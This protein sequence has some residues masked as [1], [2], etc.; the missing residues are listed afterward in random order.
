MNASHRTGRAGPGTGL[1]R[2]ALPVL[3]LAGLALF[4]LSGAHK[5]FILQPS[6]RTLQHIEGLC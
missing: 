1:A 2:R 3:L 5:F 6:G 4:F